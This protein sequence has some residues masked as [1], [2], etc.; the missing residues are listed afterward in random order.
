VKADTENRERVLCAH[1]SCVKRARDFAEEIA[2]GYGFDANARYEL[3]LAMS[4]AV[5]NAIQHGSSSTADRVAIWAEDESGALT[6]YV[7]DTGQFVARDAN[8]CDMRESGRGL[9]FM[10]RLMDEVEVRR[11]ADGTVV[12]FSKR[13]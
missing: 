5:T 6:F 7:R 11:G 4:E 10:R 2:A 3:K 9:E 13:R 12:R 1:L 8:G